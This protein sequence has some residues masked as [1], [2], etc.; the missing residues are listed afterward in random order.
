MIDCSWF[1]V[2]SFCI[3]KAH[4]LLHGCHPTHIHIKPLQLSVEQAILNHIKTVTLFLTIP[5]PRRCQFKCRFLPNRKLQMLNQAS[6]MKVHCACQGEMEIIHAIWIF[7]SKMK[8]HV[9]CTAWCVFSNGYKQFSL[10]EK[11]P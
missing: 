11:T 4:T 8:E 6:Q 7:S 5:Y 2:T 9:I 10:L 1:L 3:L